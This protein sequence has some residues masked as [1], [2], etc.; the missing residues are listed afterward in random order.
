MRVMKKE[1]IETL[2]QLSRK[3]IT[4]LEGFAED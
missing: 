4:G 2:T 1:E 3:L